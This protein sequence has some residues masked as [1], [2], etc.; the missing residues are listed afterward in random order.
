MP[1]EKKEKASSLFP[2][3]VLNFFYKLG[4]IFLF[5][6]LLRGGIYDAFF[7]RSGQRREHSG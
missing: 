7:R 4:E 5:F 2:N 6:I 3:L 1:V